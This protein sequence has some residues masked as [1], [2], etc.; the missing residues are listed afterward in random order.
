MVAAMQGVPTIAEKAKMVVS[1]MGGGAE[2]VA[3]HIEIANKVN[4]NKLLKNEPVYVKAISAVENAGRNFGVSRTG[5]VGPM[6]VT[7]LVAR[8]YGLNKYDPEENVLAGRLYIE[9]L[10]KQFRGNR[11]LAYAAYNAGP[12]TIRRAVKNAGSTDWKDVK[13]HLFEALKYYEKVIK[14][15]AEKKIVEAMNYPEKVM[16]Y[17]EVLG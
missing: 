12:A 11:M 2:K 3:E 5:V 9:D 4:S 14:V 15:P 17:E 16:A 6:Q 7:G 10:I 8:S 1:A 13:K